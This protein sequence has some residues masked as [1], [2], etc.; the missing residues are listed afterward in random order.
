MSRERREDADER[1]R[2]DGLEASLREVYAEVDAAHAGWS[3]EASTDC[4][5][6]ARTGREPYVTS[7][8]VRLVERAVRA[9]GAKV[10]AK[11]SLPVA[12][13]AATLVG[14]ERR[15][16]ML[17]DGGRCSVY[18]ARPFG[19][20]TFYCERATPGDRVQQRDINRWVARIRAIAGAYTPGHDTGAPLT[21]AL[22][23]RAAGRDRARH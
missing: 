21:R 17:D 3:C 4:C 15:C 8:E 10:D 16:P 14:G 23:G 9:R 22:H 13:R 11:R 5:H 2:V 7:I 19:C 18:A 6:F 1:R 20:R 12:G